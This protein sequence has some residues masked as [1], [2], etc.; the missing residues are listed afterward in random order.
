MNTPTKPRYCI[1]WE[2]G[3]CSE[4]RAVGRRIAKI[5]HALEGINGF[6]VDGK[7]DLQK[8]VDRLR[9]EIIEGLRRD[10]W[11]LRVTDSDRWSILPPKDMY[12]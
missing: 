5:L 11:R 8:D 3:L 2:A 7:C 6:I 4:A 1:P 10:G 12:S 9:V